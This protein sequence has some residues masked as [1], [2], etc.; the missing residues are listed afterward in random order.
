MLHQAPPS[1]AV[2]WVCRVHAEG[3]KA[4]SIMCQVQVARFKDA[5]GVLWQDTH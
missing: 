3:S 5:S 4:N 1:P 2:K